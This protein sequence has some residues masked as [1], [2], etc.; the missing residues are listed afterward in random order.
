M[1]HRAPPPGF[2]SAIQTFC[3][4]AYDIVLSLRS[5]RTEYQWQQLDISNLREQDVEWIEDYNV[6][7]GGIAQ[8]V[9]AKVLFSP[10]YKIIDGE[11]V[12]L[13]KGTVLRS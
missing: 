7:P 12:L 3:N 10:L 8:G 6:S 5:C 4:F 1:Q 2:D 9:P 13:R 11:R